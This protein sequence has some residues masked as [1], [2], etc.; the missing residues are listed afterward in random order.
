MKKYLILI[1]IA[2]CLLCTSCKDE[3][4]HEYIDGICD[5]GE[6]DPNYKPPHV[7]EFVDGKCSCGET[8]PNYKPPHVHEFVDGKCSC[9]EKD[10]NYE[11]PHVHE[12]ID[13]KCSCG[14]TDPNYEPPHV[15]EFI[16][17]KC[18]C[19]ETDPNYKPPHTHEF[20][21]G[22]CSCGEIEEKIYTITFKD[23]DG[24][25]LKTL[26]VKQG[27]IINPP[28]DPIREGYI[29][30][31]WDHDLEN[32]SS[33]LEV[34][35]RYYEEEVSYKISF[36]IPDN[37]WYYETKEEMIKDFLNDFYDFVKPIESRVAFIY[38]G[39]TYDA[40]WSNYIGGS[41]GYVNYLL[42]NND[43]EANNDDY[44]FNS[45]QYKTKWYK[46]S[47]YVKNEV[48]KTNKRFGYS[49]VT[50]KYGALDFKRYIENDPEG[51]VSNY[52]G[53]SIFYGYPKN[54][55]V[56]PTSY[57][58]DSKDIILPIPTSTKFMG[59]YDNPNF[60]GD[61][62][63][64]IPTGSTG[65]KQY[66]AKI[67]DEKFVIDFDTKDDLIIDE[68][69][70]SQ[71]SLVTLP[72]ITKDGYKFLG[73]YLDYDLVD[74]EF[75]YDYDVSI[76]LSAKWQ[77]IGKPSYS[78][79]VYDGKTITYRNSFVAVELPDQYVQKETE[80][81][82]AWV[83]SFTNSYTPSTN[84]ELMKKA[85]MEVLD[86]LE[87]YNMNCMIFHI[88]THN[89]A[90]Y[91]TNLAPIDKEYGTYESFENWDYLTWLIDECHS[92]GIEFHAWLNPYRIALSGIKLDKTTTDVAKDYI[93]YP[94]NPASN[95]DN[96]LMT[97]VSTG[98]SQ[99]AILNPAKEVV[100]NY[101]VDVCVE[102]AKNY[103]VDA[104]H[105]DDYFYQRLNSDD[106]AILKDADQSD[107]V[108]Y[109]KNNSTNLKV[110]SYLDKQTWRRYNV[111]CLIEKIH[112]AL[113]KL[114]RKVA[115]GISP[116]GT[117]K[118]GDGSV[119]SGSNTT[120][121]GH[122][123]APLFCDTYKWIKEGW[124]DYIMPQCYTSFDYKNYSF[125]DITTWWNKAVE[126]TN[127]DLYIGLALS[128]SYSEDYLYSWATEPYELTNQLLYLNT[129]ENVKGVSLFSFTTLKNI[130]N[131]SNLLA[132]PALQ[133]L[134]TEFWND[135][136]NLP[137]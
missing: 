25:V 75:I 90:F 60:S 35:A 12:F 131:D 128:N 82:A 8:D 117:Y 22:K 74:N 28:S 56:K 30:I 113:N 39:T 65:N 61:V 62:I 91:K 26:Q 42:Y 69:I 135:E 38:G 71:N 124:I 50:Y 13:G 40:T 37:L 114:D 130:H 31:G 66:Y 119:E 94:L 89:N 36:V 15:H 88:R 83:S 18:S 52:G 53:T 98:R 10:P 111:D 86:L 49:D 118:S 100:Q 3:H 105:F 19:G 20:I 123:N 116:T 23:Y 41:E 45:S 103:N 96:I 137:K 85:L 121:M 125:H 115:F 133:K 4:T 48:C 64:T 43:I 58:S 127:V 87:Y 6:I 21:D 110:D 57:T 1:L 46:L 34:N 5:C 72:A 95:P 102:V 29:F 27:E 107:Y 47:S 99:G 77:E 92:R 73:W 80:L 101:L 68:I 7:H 97:Y 108:E 33:D 134:K 132:Y 51:Y 112:N 9:G 24:T 76:K 109:L 17:G 120:P 104:I 54:D 14:E 84:P 93:D 78:N 136:V 81:R 32:I 11:P 129:L 70:V 55:L 2:L 122:Y 106:T 79:L 44:F 63:D 67:V 16:D 59:W 126:N